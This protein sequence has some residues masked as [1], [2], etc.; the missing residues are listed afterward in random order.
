MLSGTSVR[1][2]HSRHESQCH[3]IHQISGIRPFPEQR[4]QDFVIS[5]DQCDDLAFKGPC[6]YRQRVM[7]LGLAV[8]TTEFLIRS[9]IADRTSALKAKG[10][11]PYVFLVLHDAKMKC[12]GHK[13]NR[14]CT[15][16]S[17]SYV[18]SFFLISPPGDKINFRSHK[19]DSKRIKKIKIC[20]P[21]AWKAYKLTVFYFT[22]PPTCRARIMV[23]GR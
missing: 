11:F 16:F 22:L 6:G 3:K 21:E 12:F 7:M 5:V 2:D 23:Q 17:L 18:N 10:R 20:I 9:S 15:G 1:S 19:K 13:N 14:L 4:V 8:I